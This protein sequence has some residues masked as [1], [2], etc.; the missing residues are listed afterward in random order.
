MKWLFA[1]LLA[2]A[3]FGTAAY[4]SYNL[5]K[6]AIAVRQEQSGEVSAEPTPDVSLP[7][8]QAAAQLRQDGKLVEA[9]NALTGFIQKYPNGIHVDEAKDV[10]GRVNIDILFSPI[11]SPEKQEYIVK[12][13]DVINRVAQKMKST[14]ELIMR[15]NNMN[16]TMLHIGDKLQISHPDFEILIQRKLKLLVLVNHKEFFKQYRTREEKLPGKQAP[17][18]TTHVAEIMAW[19]GGKRV[20]FGTRE[21]ATST[22]WVR[23]AAPGYYLYSLPDASHPAQEQPPPATGIGLNA[24]DIEELSSLVNSK[25]PVTV[26]D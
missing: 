7:E 2:V 26:T 10:L 15:T 19:K 24:G 1:L 18:V 21:Y 20:G 14:P 8:F 22:R 3:I 25:T 9:R 5:A 23:L 13:G 4:F 11:A 6:P 17:R 16:G 12:K